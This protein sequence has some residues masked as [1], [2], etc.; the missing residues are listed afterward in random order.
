MTGSSMDDA[1]HKGSPEN[2]ADAPVGD[3]SVGGTVGSRPVAGIIDAAPYADRKSSSLTAAARNILLLA[4]PLLGSNLL[5][6]LAGTGMNIWFGRLIGDSAIAIFSVF[7][8]VMFF[9]VS[10]AMGLTTGA[11]V[12]VGQASG[13]G[14]ETGVRAVVGTTL[15]LVLILGFALAL[16]GWAFIDPLLVLVGTPT[17]LLVLEREYALSMLC[18]VPVL[19]LFLAYSALL[20][21]VGQV[22]IAL[23]MVVVTT[24]LSLTL[25]P[26]LI[27]GPFGHGGYGV[28]SNAYACIVA[29]LVALVWLLFHLARTGSTLAFS[30][31]HGAPLKFDLPIAW[32]I[33]RIGVPSSLQMV[34]TSLS[35]I[36][37]TALVGRYGLEAV[38]GFGAANQLIGYVLYPAFSVSIA[39]S[40]LGAHAFGAQDHDRMFNLSRAAIILA[41]LFSSAI[42]IV[43]FVMSRPLLS[44][45]ISDVKSILIAVSF[46]NY[47]LVGLFFA[48]ITAVITAMLRAVGDVI[49]PTVIG[50]AAIW[51]VQIPLA[52]E[53]ASHFGL[54]GV[55]MSFPISQALNWLVLQIYSV[56]SRTCLARSLS[57]R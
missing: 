38:A 16:V 21:G 45:F 48:G 33:V 34:F 3:E 44:L 20:R 13:A 54:D 18:F 27:I 17:D 10:L 35:L 15:P 8:P 52:Y 9:M 26:I 47:S 24:A 39:A 12:L 49:A 41:C 46:L 56:R 25:A 6:S 22:K 2:L 55:W 57:P 4:Y 42:I 11:T 23:R 28:A 51:G 32:K 40:I 43:V 53:L 29:Y 1:L 14:D 36:W 5:N 7:F 30:L 31:R 50:L 19:F 37:L